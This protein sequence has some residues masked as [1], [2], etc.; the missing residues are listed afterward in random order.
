MSN[1]TFHF[2]FFF[3]ANEA[4]K[5]TVGQNRSNPETGTS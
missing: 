2:V 3:A 4:E 5:Q 1:S